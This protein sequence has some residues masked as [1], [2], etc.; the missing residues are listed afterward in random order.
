MKS[1]CCRSGRREVQDRR[2]PAKRVAGDLR[3]FGHA[4]DSVFEEG[5]AGAKDPVLMAAASSENRVLPTLDK[6]IANLQRYPAEQHA[7]VVLFRPVRSGRLTVLAFVRERLHEILEL[8]LR[9]RLIVVGPT[10]IRIR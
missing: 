1:V 5:L 7:G 4:A 6:G 3:G 2:E 10:R 8:D 9:G